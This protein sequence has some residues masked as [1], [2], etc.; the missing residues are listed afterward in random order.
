MPFAL[1]D[2]DDLEAGSG[3][4]GRTDQWMKPAAETAPNTGTG[5]E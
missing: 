3:A 5:E 1:A 4:R 2:F